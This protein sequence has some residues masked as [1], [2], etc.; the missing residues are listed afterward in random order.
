M[1]S[2]YTGITRIIHAFGYS[3]AGLKSV[4]RT[5]A[6]F[7]QDLLLCV[8]GIAV[9]FFID[10]PILYRVLMLASLPL[11]LIAELVNTAIET[12]VDRIGTEKNAMS[13]RAK[14]IGS[15]IVLITISL[16]IALWVA[17]IFIA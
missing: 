7:R 17:L 11:I 1:K 8:I 9:Q 13:G 12:I 14:D 3:F 10:V 6:A 4:F 5:E 15:A 2:K 16:V